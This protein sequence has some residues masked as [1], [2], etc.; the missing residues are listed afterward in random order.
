MHFCLFNFGQLLSY[1][2][3]INVQWTFQLLF[4][5][6]LADL[7]LLFR[8]FLGFGSKVWNFG[9]IGILLAT[10]WLLFGYFLATFQLL[11]GYFHLLF[12]NFYATFLCYFRTVFLSKFEFFNLSLTTCFMNVSLDFLSNQHYTIY[13]SK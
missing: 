13:R 8:N 11:F 1:N 6:F 12:C 3:Q 4:G 7:W 5:Y 10:F 2:F 9:Y